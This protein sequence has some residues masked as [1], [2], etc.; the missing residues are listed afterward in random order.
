MKL[1]AIKAMFQVG[2]VV[3]VTRSG[4]TPIVIVGNTGT[5]VMPGNNGTERR[6]ITACRSG[7]WIMA[8][9]DGRYVHTTYPKAKEVM[10]VG[11]GLLN[12]QYDNGTVITI[13]KEGR[14]P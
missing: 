11:E 1:A 5:T 10:Y 4:N 14:K 7:D 12:F 2:D 13:E 9:P 3:L 6:T 8:K